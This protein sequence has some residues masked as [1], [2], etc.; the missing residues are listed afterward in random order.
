MDQCPDTIA[1]RNPTEDGYLSLRGI[2]LHRLLYTGSS[3]DVLPEVRHYA[4][5][6]RLLSRCDTVSKFSL[7]YV[8]PGPK[9]LL[10]VLLL[11]LQGA[12]KEQL[13]EE[14]EQLT[15]AVS[16]SLKICF[17]EQEF[18]PLQDNPSLEE[19]LSPSRIEDAAEIA[20]RVALLFTASREVTRDVGFGYSTAN[21]NCSQDSRREKEEMQYV[22]PFISTLGPLIPLCEHLVLCREPCLVDISSTPI[23]KGEAYSVVPKAMEESVALCEDYLLTAATFTRRTILSTRANALRQFFWAQRHLL[24]TP[25]NA[26][27]VWIRIAS[28]GP[29]DPSLMEAVGN[30]LTAP[31]SSCDAQAQCLAGGFNAWHCVPDEKLRSV[32]A[33]LQE[34]DKCDHA[35]RYWFDAESAG[36]LLQF[37]RAEDE[38]YPGI[39]VYTARVLRASQS[40][41]RS[42]P[43]MGEAD[44]LGEKATVRLPLDETFRPA[45]VR[46]G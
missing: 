13:R 32:L 2:R 16:S 46:A 39:P 5:L 41:P 21:L 10:I 33:E 36:F 25:G 37:P 31:V 35:T 23:N 34:E 42:G 38:D 18:V 28:P 22:F 6:L 26:M 9:E 30:S 24:D 3:E 4:G 15:Q 8:V 11:C 7:R 20:R 14:N 27:L 45:V 19:V 12:K 40:L 29:T 17:R 1:K 44:V 43:L